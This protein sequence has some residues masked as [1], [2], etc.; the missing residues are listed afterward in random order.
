MGITEI[1]KG[2]WKMLR[3]FDYE[4][5]KEFEIFADSNQGKKGKVY[6]VVYDDFFKSYKIK[7]ELRQAYFKKKIRLL[8]TK[9]K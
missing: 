9:Y 5:G 7:S 8:E 2:E 4:K 1:I 3:L 6:H